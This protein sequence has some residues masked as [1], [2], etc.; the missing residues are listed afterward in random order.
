MYVGLSQDTSGYTDMEWFSM[1]VVF[2]DL[3]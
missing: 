1:P 2:Q 3:C